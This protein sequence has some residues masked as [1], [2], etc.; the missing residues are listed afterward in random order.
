MAHLLPLFREAEERDGE[1]RHVFIEIPLSSI[2][3]PLVPHGARRLQN[4]V[5][6]QSLLHRRAPRQRR[7]HQIKYGRG[8]ELFFGRFAAQQAGNPVFQ[9]REIERLGKKI[10]GMHRHGA[11]GHVAGKRAYENDG[12][13]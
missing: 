5:L 11:P 6:R 9:S 2:L 1:R 7:T 13:F 12:R 8:V 10:H 4:R 3:S